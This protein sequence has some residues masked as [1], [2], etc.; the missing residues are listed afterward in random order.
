MHVIV[1][2]NTPTLYIP[3]RSKRSWTHNHLSLDLVTQL[4]R[5]LQLLGRRLH[6]LLA[7]GLQIAVQQ[8]LPLQLTNLSAQPSVS[9]IL[10]LVLLAN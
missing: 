3:C 4:L 2:Q 9:N 10:A 6:T 5:L 8:H 1:E 7:P